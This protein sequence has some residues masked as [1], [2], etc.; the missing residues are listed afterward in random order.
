[1]QWRLDH[2]EKPERAI[3]R[4]LNPIGLMAWLLMACA[5][6]QSEELG[7]LFFTPEQRARLDYSYARQAKSGNIAN[8]SGVTLNGIVQRHGGKR[9]AW[10]N[11]SPQLVGNGDE[12][13]PESVSVAIPGQNK[14]VKLKVGQRVYTGTTQSTEQSGT[15]NQGSQ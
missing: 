11:G 15:A 8:E 3:M 6:A 12:K 1:M 7:R 4:H 9:T 5:P 2:P 14:P 13:A 10:I